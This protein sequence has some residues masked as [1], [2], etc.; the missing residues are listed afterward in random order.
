[1][2]RSRGTGEGDDAC[3]LN[4][5][6]MPTLHLTESVLSRRSSA[7]PVRTGWAS[8]WVAALLMGTLTW[9]AQAQWVQ[10]RFTDLDFQLTDGGGVGASVQCEV[11]GVAGAIS[12]VMLSLDISGSWSGDLYAY[13]NL[14]GAHAVLLNRV[15]KTASNPFGYG[16]QGFQ[17]GFDDSAVNGDIHQYRVTYSLDPPLSSTGA[18][19]GTWAPDGRTT[20]PDLVL[21]T[22]PR[23][24]T[25]GA[26]TG[27]NPNGLWTLFLADLVPGSVHTLQAWELS[28][29]TESGPEP[30]VLR[31]ARVAG[32]IEIRFIG[33]A[34]LT[35]QL[36][37]APG[38]PAQ[39]WRVLRTRTGDGGEIMIGP[40]STQEATGFFR[41]QILPPDTEP[42]QPTLTILPV[43]GGI[44]FRFFGES[45][46]AYRLEAAPRLPVEKWQVLETRTG[47]GVEI[48]LGPFA[49][50]QTT[51][52]FRARAE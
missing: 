19:T 43:A 15:G 30:P 29:R 28:I 17:V 35:Y 40:L 21:D 41:V 22:D 42:D 10:Y 44:E 46:V 49:T 6:S 13:L 32:G 12:H 45:G 4:M 7:H 33:K 51:G 16:D 34:G 36:E 37:T 25:L 31:M 27:M 2:F 8:P 47:E 5:V 52:F 3:L 11:S 18:L 1:M 38:L 48:V 50:Q 26:F 24:A 23:T 9:G 20:D 39:S 14:G